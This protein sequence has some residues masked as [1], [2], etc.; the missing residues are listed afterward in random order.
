M[1]RII[2]S[3]CP[4]DAAP[5][6]RE[7]F[8]RLADDPATENWIVLHSLDIANHVSQVMGE[9]D[10]IVII[11]GKGVVCLEIK[12]HYQIR[13]D[14]DGWWFGK[15]T[16][17]ESR[18]PFRQAADAM[19]SLREYACG[20]D[21]RF[22]G[23]TWTSGVIFPKAAG[24]APLIS[25]EW[26]AWQLV[27]ATRLRAS[28]ISRLILSMLT[29]ARTLLSDS[30]GV[31]LPENSVSFDQEAAE[32]LVQIL[33]PSFEIFESP[34]ARA[35]NI[36][37]EL[38]T[39]TAEQFRALDHMAANPRVVFRGP[40]GT[41]KTLVAIEAMR[42]FRESN[43]S[44]CML[45]CFNTKLSHWL[46]QEI[47]HISKE[48]EAK[49]ISQLMVQVAGRGP[50]S[51]EQ[52]DQSFWEE[53][54]PSLAIDRLLEASDDFQKLDF[55]IVDEAQ[56]ILKPPFLDFLDL[57]LKGGLGSGRWLMFG[58]FENQ[59][60]FK[61]GSIHLEEFI[62]ERAPGV[63]IY[64]LRD[65]CRNTPRVSH[66]VEAFGGLRPGYSRVLRADDRNEPQL[67]F[68]SNS[69]D[70]I[71]K[72]E[73][74]ISLL[75]QDHFSPNEIVILSPKR[76]GCAF[77]LQKCNGSTQ[78]LAPFGKHTTKEI[79]WC[80]IHAFKGLEAPA[81]I[82]TDISEFENEESRS[83]LYVALTRSLRHLTILANSNTK[84][85]VNRLLFS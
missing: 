64:E 77:D 33:R 9:A 56:D 38:K 57:I 54:L 4:L 1:A 51:A 45:I 29:N 47:K 63:P 70:Q 53:P 85:Q 7:V 26:H 34:K 76:E 52:Y 81:I 69:S 27:D 79:P 59:A 49:T 46:H 3:V 55:L 50:S 20:K 6:E 42:R 36:S 44:K 8:R 66:R 40:A 74:I 68:Y 71:E 10:F 39:Y 30:V 58:D 80:T 73:E 41:G 23:I 18:G 43:G 72:L 48:S 84:D 32:F 78:R 83:L 60:I 65:N 11:P 62:S 37:S 12:S 28:P 19:H 15:K 21:K 61:N 17:P 13:R 2:P 35:K 67:S 31:R 14:Q 25:G 16:K 22:S 75:S 5:G 82:V 24:P